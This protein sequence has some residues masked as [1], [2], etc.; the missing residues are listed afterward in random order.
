[1]R[2]PTDWNKYESNPN[3]FFARHFFLNYVTKAYSDLLSGIEFEKPIE[4]LEFGCGTGYIDKWLCKKFK[5]RKVTLID[6]NK[7]M[8][9]LTKKTFSGARCETDFL[10]M[11]FFKFSPCKNMISSIARG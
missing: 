5:V 3:S 11:D 6:S 8:L 4:I 1:M 7:K 10:E 2:T 9:N